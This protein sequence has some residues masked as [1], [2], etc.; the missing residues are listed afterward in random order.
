MKRA[1]MTTLILA[2]LVFAQNINGQINTNGDNAKLEA[3]I[4]KVLRDQKEN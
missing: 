1:F 4:G 3:E 2:V